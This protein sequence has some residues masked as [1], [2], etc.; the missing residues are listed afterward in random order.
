MNVIKKVKIWL[1]A[2]L[3][4]LASSIAMLTVALITWLLCSYH[5]KDTLMDDLS[6]FDYQTAVKLFAQV[7]IVVVLSLVVV[8]L[9]LCIRSFV[10]ASRSRKLEKIVKKAR[11]QVYD[12]EKYVFQNYFF[13]NADAVRAVAPA[14]LLLCSLEQ[15][16]DELKALNESSPLADTNANDEVLVSK[17]ALNSILFSETFT[18]VPSSIEIEQCE[19]LIMETLSSIERTISQC[20]IKY[21]NKSRPRERKRS[22]A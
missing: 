22:V 10:L 4:L 6:K 3:K 17:N 20:H 9:G 1:L 18:K 5:N 14:R 19:K 21:R 12:L 7:I 16:L 2:T 8:Y 11:K 13:M 15:K